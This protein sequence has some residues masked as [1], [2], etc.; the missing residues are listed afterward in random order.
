MDGNEWIPKNFGNLIYV[1][2]NQI[3]QEPNNK[4]ASTKIINHMTYGCPKLLWPMPAEPAKPLVLPT[5]RNAPQLIRSGNRLKINSRYWTNVILPKAQVTCRCLIKTIGETKS[6]S[7]KRLRHLESRKRW[8]WTRKIREKSQLNHPYIQLNTQ[9]YDKVSIS[10][11]W[12]I[13]CKDRN[14]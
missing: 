12:N 8:L 10:S 7:L 13:E 9:D 6:S 11:K 2:Q 3:Y 14:C 4:I 5:K 1:K